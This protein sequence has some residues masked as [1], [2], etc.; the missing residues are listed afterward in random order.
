M[1]FDSIKAQFFRK[2]AKILKLTQKPTTLPCNCDDAKLTSVTIPLYFPPLDTL[3]PKS[4]ITNNQFGW[5][6]DSELDFALCNGLSGDQKKMCQD[7]ISNQ[8]SYDV[9]NNYVSYN[10]CGTKCQEFAWKWA[11]MCLSACKKAGTTS[12]ILDTRW[13]NKSTY[14]KCTEGYIE[15]SLCAIDA[16]YKLDSSKIINRKKYNL[17]GEKEFNKM[18][19]NCYPSFG[20]M[21]PLRLNAFG[22]VECFTFDGKNCIWGQASDVACKNFIDA[23]YLK[24]IPLTCGSDAMKKYWGDNGYVNPNYWCSKMRAYY[25]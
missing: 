2:L 23:N 20:Y 12:R 16:D 4:T 21:G 8:W 17:P 5:W 7:R 22:D 25:N 3:P 1:V 6:Y 15:K 18:R 10:K 24:A 13:I 19:W 14:F 9:Q 11:E